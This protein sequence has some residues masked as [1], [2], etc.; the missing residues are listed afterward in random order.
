MAD[1]VGKFYLF[2]CDKGIRKYLSLKS[3][4]CS[5]RKYWKS[6]IAVFGCIKMENDYRFKALEHFKPTLT[7]R[8]KTKDFLY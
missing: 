4:S 8:R 3:L 2:T 5:S 7:D 1:Y 6:C